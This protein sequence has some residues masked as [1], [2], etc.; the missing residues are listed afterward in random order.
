MHERPCLTAETA[1]Q[2]REIFPY[3]SMSEKLPHQ[4]ISIRT[5]LGK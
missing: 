5:G 2:Y 1:A 3:G 4:R